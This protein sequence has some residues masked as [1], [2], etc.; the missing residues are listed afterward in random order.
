M[1]KVMRD[2]VENDISAWMRS[3]VEKRGRNAD[4]AEKT[5]S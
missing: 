3:I 1:D 2:K 4:L 5:D